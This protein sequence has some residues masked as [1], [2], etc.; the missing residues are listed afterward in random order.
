MRARPIPYCAPSIGQE[1]SDEVLDSIRNGW[2]TTG[3]KVEIFEN[4]FAEFVGAKHAIAVN[5][6]TTALTL[7]LAALDIGP[8]DEVIVPTLTFCAAANVVEHRGATAILVDV[9]QD[10]QIDPIAIERA[11]SSKTR[12]IIP[13][14]FGGQACDLNAILELGKCHGIAVVQDAAHAVGAQYNGLRLGAHG[15]V[16]AFSFYPSKNMTTGEGGMLTTDDEA[17]AARLRQL[18]RFGI[19]RDAGNKADGNRSWYYEV[20]EPGYKANMMDLQAAIGIHQLRKLEGFIER[21]RAIANRYS[22]AFADLNEFLLPR[23]LPE[24]PHVHYLYTVRIIAESSKITRD[25]L[26]REL[27]KAGVGTSVHFIPLHKHP[28]YRAKYGDSPTLFP[29]ADALYDQIVSLPL[30]P[31]MSDQDVLDVIDAVCRIVFTSRN[32]SD[33]MPEHFG[34]NSK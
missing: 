22:A 13:V 9:G 23:D 11:I 31:A 30:Y 17:F 16:T 4:S 12:A 20:R 10:F 14:H 33:P 3:P 28:F 15:L 24:R 25:N 1:E 26:I 27:D 34:V 2:L 21:R 7:A 29:V 19:S 32:N 5:S 18:S 8:G 6:C